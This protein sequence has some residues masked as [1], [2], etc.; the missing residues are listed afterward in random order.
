MNITT[1][2]VTNGNGAGQIRAT[3]S[4]RQRTVAYDHAYSPEWN[5]GN[6]AGTLALVLITGYTARKVA[7][8]TAKVV[9]HRHNGKMRFS[10]GV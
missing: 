10:L 4:G 8:D 9:Q 5:H 2:Y 6:A 3:G 7:A 1:T